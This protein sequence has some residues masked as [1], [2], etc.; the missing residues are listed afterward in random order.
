MDKLLVDG[1]EIDVEVGPGGAEIT[2]GQSTVKL[3]GEGKL[4]GAQAFGNTVERI[5]G[6]LIIT[7]PN[8]AK[9]KMGD[10]GEVTLL[11][12]PSSVGILDVSTVASYTVRADGENIIH[13]VSFAGGGHAQI[14]YC[15]EQ[16][17]A[18]SCHQV[19]QRINDDNE[20][21]IEACLQDKTA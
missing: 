14:T 12:V 10:D 13:T 11:T 17:V 9:I 18:I 4:I 5:E 2:S 6:G 16:V 8:G 20:L 15:R 7:R 3:D 1:H 21:F 19:R